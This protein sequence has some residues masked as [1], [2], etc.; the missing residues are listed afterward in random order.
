M[1]EPVK[2]MLPDLSRNR[3]L[4]FLLQA[5]ARQ[6]SWQEEDRKQVNDCMSSLS[7][8]S[9]EDKWKI[10]TGKG[11]RI[12]YVSKS[13]FN[14]YRHSDD[15]QIA[16]QN[17]SEAK[18]VL[19]ELFFD[20]T[21]S[22]AKSTPQG[23]SRNLLWSDSIPS[24]LLLASLATDLQ[25]LTQA[26]LISLVIRVNL[27]IDSIRYFYY[28][29]PATVFIS[30]TFGTYLNSS[31]FYI[32]IFFLVF[33]IMN[34]NHESKSREIFRKLELFLIS[35]SFAWVFFHSGSQIEMFV[36]FIL[37]LIGFFLDRP[38]FKSVRMPIFIV[39]FAYFLYSLLT[40]FP[41]VPIL[42][43]LL[44]A[45]T[46]LFFLLMLNRTRGFMPHFVVFFSLLTF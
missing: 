21:T 25:V 29:L 19:I 14:F 10:E 36:A 24:I 17:V 22:F 4:Y 1:N 42:A 39:G 41:V 16:R 23:N 9:F 27:K 43:R 2:P 35:V 31:L 6:I 32:F 40:Q 37:G 45:M 44:V 8:T 28:L 18:S 12:V 3:S 46:V 13:K 7:V 30:A 34:F 15:V 38:I 5:T 33:A 11:S 20:L 26:L